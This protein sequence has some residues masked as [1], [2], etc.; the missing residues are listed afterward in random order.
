[1]SITRLLSYV[2]T[3]SVRALWDLSFDEDNRMKM[4]TE[5]KLELISVLDKMKASDNKL[6]SEAAYGT[7]WNLRDL[8]QNSKLERFRNIGMYY[9]S[10]RCP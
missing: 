3:E 6:I 1:M 2:N 8:L 4:M 7:L 5:E 9:N 10:I